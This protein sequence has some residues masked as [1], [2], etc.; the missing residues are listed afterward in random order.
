MTVYQSAATTRASFLVFFVAFLKALG[1]IYSW[2]FVFLMVLMLGVR[3]PWGNIDFNV[4]EIATTVFSVAGTMVALILPASQLANAFIARMED[5]TLR[6]ILEDPSDTQTKVQAVHQITN[7]LRGNL[8]PAWRASSF[9]F[10][11]FL[12]ATLA[13]I[14]PSSDLPLG[15]SPLV[16]SVDRSIIA[17]SLGCLLVGSAWFLPTARYTFSLDVLTDIEHVVET[18]AQHQEVQSQTGTQGKKRNTR[19]RAGKR[20]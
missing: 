4:R 10:V 2:I 15:S 7:S 19:A 20:S 14:I 1:H 8:F 9:V 3:S 17:I 13:M 12:F 18:I 16:M 6:V 5:E 11:S